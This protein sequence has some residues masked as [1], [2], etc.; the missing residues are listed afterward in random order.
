MKK[1]LL[2][3]INVLLWT[4]SSQA[5]WQPDVRLTNNTAESNFPQITVSGTVV[6]VVWMDYRD[7][8]WEIYYKRSNDGGLSWLGDT[9]LTTDSSDSEYASITSSETVVHVVWIDN[10]DGNWEIYYKQSTD[11]GINWTPDTRLTNNTADSWHPKITVSGTV[12]HVV[13]FDDRDGNS[14]IY[15]KC[16]NDGGISWLGD[17]RLTTDPSNSYFPSVTSSGTVVHVVWYDE[18][19]FEI[20]YKQSTDEGINWTPG[21]RLTNNTAVSWYPQITVSGTVVHVVWYDERNANFEI[22][23]KR[24]NDGG[25]SWLGDTRL[26]TDPSISESPSITSSGT[27]V[28]V[29]WHDNLDWEIYYKQSTDGGI[30]WIPGTR[31]TNNT[32]YSWYPQITV[33]GTVAHVVWYDNRDGNAE[34]YYKQDPT[35]NP[36]SVENISTEIPKDF[37]LYQNYPNPF[38]PSTKIKFTIPSVGT[39]L[40]KFVQ[41]KVYDILGNEVATL[42]NEEK[43]AGNYEIEFNAIATNRDLSLSSGI[44]FYQLKAGEFIQTK[45]M[46]LLR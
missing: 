27:V 6:H 5:Q 42:V 3:I 17:A 4:V 26:T 41:L 40:M 13:W 1:F 14:E 18:E 19:N 15:Y 31:L 39:S 10:R 12:V 38:N 16:S 34:I 20:Y 22:Y 24:S 9:R 32:A 28:H 37:M 11:G 43:P 8:N 23:Y 33:S 29:V 7:G 35:G 25:L 45:K 30:N 36:V 44:Y 46:I 2:L 21:T